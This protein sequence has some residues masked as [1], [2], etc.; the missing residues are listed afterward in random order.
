MQSNKRFLSPAEVL[1]RTGLAAGQ[2]VVDLGAGSGFFALASGKMVGNE[3]TVYVVDVL[4]KSLEH[5]AAEARLNKLRNL[6]TI[7]HDLEKGEVD[8]IPGGV[9]DLVVVAN[10]IHQIKH[11]EHLMNE[12]YRVLKTSGKLLVVDWNSRP[13]SFGP[14][15]SERVSEN[16]VKELAGK[17][18]LKFNENV[19]TDEFH[20]G[21]IFTK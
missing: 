7:R 15:A 9:A 3:G 4:E 20:Y 14:K 11:T 5:V 18:S 1:F 19:E 8:E 2:N 10:L 17:Y 6:K 13:V 16:Q 21:L 12:I